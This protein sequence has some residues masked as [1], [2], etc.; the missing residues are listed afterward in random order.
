MFWFM[1]TLYEMRA[2]LCNQS[3]KFTNIDIC[4]TQIAIKKKFN[5][6]TLFQYILDQERYLKELSI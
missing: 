5:P 6:V 1:M 4:K 3:S 2:I